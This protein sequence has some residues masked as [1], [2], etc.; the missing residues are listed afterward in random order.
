MLLV[1]ALIAFYLATTIKLL[2][3]LKRSK[4]SGRRVQLKKVRKFKFVSFLDLLTRLGSTN[5][6]RSKCVLASVSYSCF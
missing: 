1:A 6:S 2:M 4:A 5:R 3:R